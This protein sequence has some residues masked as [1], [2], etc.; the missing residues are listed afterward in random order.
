MLVA[1]EQC[2]SYLHPPAGRTREQTLTIFTM[3]PLSLSVSVVARATIFDSALNCSKH[4]K[5]ANR[6]A[7]TTRP[8]SSA[9]RIYSFDS[10]VGERL[11]ALAEI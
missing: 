3:D 8:T 11:S 2:Q 6:S 1:I 7:R 4:V 10:H 5:V 9:F